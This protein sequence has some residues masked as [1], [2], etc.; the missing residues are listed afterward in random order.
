[1]NQKLYSYSIA[2]LSRQDYSEYKLRM[3]LKT[4]DH[5][6][7]EIDEVINDLKKKNFL[8]EDNYKRLFIRKWIQKGESPEKI[9]MRAAQER[10]EL[11]S[12]DFSNAQQEL[13]ITNSDSIEKLI[14]KKLRSKEIPADPENKKALKDKTLRFLI[15]K[16]HRYDQAS[17]AL[18]KIFNSNEYIEQLD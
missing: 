2:L 10:L 6:P 14:S 12:E 15:S 17:K 3:K 7:H 18:N 1:M 4:R 9:K 11:S 8:R 16:G 5:L 13:G